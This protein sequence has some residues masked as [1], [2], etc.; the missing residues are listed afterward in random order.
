MSRTD[1]VGFAVL[2]SLV[3]GPSLAL[4]N[5]PPGGATSEW[6]GK[7]GDGPGG[8]E[9]SVDLEESTP[10]LTQEVFK[11]SLGAHGEWYASERYGEVWRP[12]VAIGWRPYYYGSWLWTDEG[13]YWNSDEPFSWAVYHYGRWVFDPS[14]GWVWVPGYQ[15]APAWVTWRFGGDA[16][17]WAPLGPGVSVFVTAYPFVDFWWTFVPTSRFV[18]VPAYT[19]AYGPRDTHRWYRATAPAPP[20]TL[21][22]DR[23]GR[24]APVAAPAWGGPSRRVIEERTGRT[25]EATRRPAAPG[26]AGRFDR[27][28]APAPDRYSPRERERPTAVPVPRR[29]TARPPDMRPEP[30][31]RERPAT[32]PAPR[33]DEDRAPPARAPGR[34]GGEPRAPR[35]R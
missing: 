11:T 31:E 5:D 20:R 30:H 17:G 28:G 29:E 9:V 18:G 2:F 23:N 6:S 24:A 15:W 7:T 26:P 25:V 27:G 1:L 19:V 22:P 16:V 34:S 3:T 12:R 8:G 14:W 32:R 4:S 13:W 35:E 33:G 10:G 21:A